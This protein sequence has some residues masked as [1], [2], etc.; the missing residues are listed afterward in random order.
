MKSFMFIFFFIIGSLVQADFCTV[1]ENRA[2]TEAAAT[3][4]NLGEI[5]LNGVTCIPPHFFE[6]MRLADSDNGLQIFAFDTK[7]ISPEAFKTARSCT[8]AKMPDQLPCKVERI[9]FHSFESNVL[10]H[11]WLSSA[12]LPELR[13]IEIIGYGQGQTYTIS[14][15]VLTGNEA[16]IRS[17]SI[18]G[19]IIA[20]KEPLIGLIQKL[21]NIENLSLKALGLVESD[22][23][24]N[25]LQGLSAVQGIDLTG[26]DDVLCAETESDF[27]SRTGLRS[28]ATVIGDFKGS[29]CV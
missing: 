23:A 20:E 5:R 22:F 16:Q 12:N 29:Q 4:V 13:E 2:A 8:H 10:P 21:E 27:K 19:A 7:Y 3:S 6:G 28:E 26:N 9:E 17:F 11:G 14:E 24:S 18:T 15:S 1:D 25:S